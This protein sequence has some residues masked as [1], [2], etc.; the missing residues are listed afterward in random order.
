MPTFDFTIPLENINQLDVTTEFGDNNVQ[1]F[2]FHPDLWGWS[3]GGYL[4][5][6][7]IWGVNITIDKAGRGP[8]LDYSQVN[9]AEYRKILVDLRIVKTNPGFFTCQLQW[10]ELSFKDLN[11]PHTVSPNDGSMTFDVPSILT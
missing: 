7:N 3:F 9:D 10:D 1:V 5:Y 2:T 6:K 8:I 11:G 4:A